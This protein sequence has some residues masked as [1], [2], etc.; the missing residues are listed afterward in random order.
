MEDVALASVL[1]EH[2]WTAEDLPGVG[3][4]FPGRT[5]VTKTLLKTLYR[6]IPTGNTRLNELWRSET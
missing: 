4:D 2:L 1:G 6:P 3:S 5:L